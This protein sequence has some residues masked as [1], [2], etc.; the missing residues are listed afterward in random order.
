MIRSACSTA[1]LSLVLAVFLNP[2]ALA[3][4]Q[5]TSLSVSS[6]VIGSS[7]TINGTGFGSSGTVRFYNGVQA[8]ISGTWTSTAVTAIVPGGAAT[9]PVTV[10]TGGVTSNG[11]NF[12]VVPNMTGFTP[13]Y[14]AVGASITIS[15]TAFGSAQ[16]TVKFNTTSATPTSWANTSIVVPVPTGVAT[17]SATVVVTTSAGVAS[18]GSTFSVVLPPSITPPLS[19]TSGNVGD[20]VTIT[21][22]NFSSNTPKVYFNGTLAVVSSYSATVIHTTVPTGATSG[23]VIVHASGVDSNPAPFSVGTSSYGARTDTNVTTFVG[24]LANYPS[25]GGLTGAN[26][27]VVDPDFHSNI[28]RI[29]DSTT[30]AAGST[31]VSQDEGGTQAWNTDSTY[32]FV[33]SVSNSPFLY[34]WNASTRQATLTAIHG[35][36]GTPANCYLPSPPSGCLTA[37]LGSVIFSGVS[38]TMAYEI[39][40]GDVQLNK[41]VITPNNG[42]TCTLPLCIIRTKL[43][44][45]ATDSTKCLPPT[46]RAIGTG[47]LGT[48]LDDQSFTMTFTGGGQNWQPT[49][50]Y[51]LTDVVLPLKNS[52]NPTAN[53]PS[54]HAFQ[55]TTAGTTAAAASEPNWSASA[56]GGTVTDGSVVWLDL[57]QMTQNNEFDIVNYTVGKGCRHIRA[58]QATVVSGDWGDI[59]PITDGTGCTPATGLSCGNTN[60]IPK[61]TLHEATQSPNASYSLYLNAGGVCKNNGITEP[62]A[63][64]NGGPF[65]WEIKTTNVRKCWTASVDSARCESHGAAGYTK[66]FLS[67]SLYPHLFASPD[68]NGSSTPPPLIGTALPTDFH[69]TYNNRNTADTN[70]VFAATVNLANTL[71]Y[72]GA[73]YDEILAVTTD[74]TTM[75]RFAHTFDTNTNATFD[76]LQNVGT[77][78]QDGKWVLFT[79]DWMNTLGC[80]DSTGHLFASTPS[81]NPTTTNPCPS[82]G[83]PRGDVFV[84]DLLSAH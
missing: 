16:G 32:F 84:V 41:L 48:S 44:N 52:V 63:Y 79:S 17:G 31:M 43:F 3:A 72:P 34:Q 54:N 8:T 61:L 68:R 75:Y 46:Y 4:P 29:T 12:T 80:V 82:G 9:G 33:R 10:S 73:Y 28:T 51:K 67:T 37:F 50:A 81:T 19:P 42:T 66:R 62:I 35:S 70:P 49:T 58:D 36:Y 83:S 55:V 60:V 2:S 1:L 23:N 5:I 38:S 39:D 65:F 78:S 30:Q 21:G 45:F 69:G 18:G 47:V 53:N 14:G 6:G 25:V 57:G 22:A 26:T 56:M 27:V 59:G 20:A 71:P 13:T 64:C 76:V 7:V 40:A 11:V 74:G 15:G 77:V 24:T